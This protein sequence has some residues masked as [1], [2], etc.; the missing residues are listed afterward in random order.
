MS[1]VFPNGS[2]TVTTGGF[3]QGM[4][5]TG[6]PGFKNYSNPASAQ[7]AKGMDMSSYKPGQA[8]PVQQSQ[9]TPYQAWSSPTGNNERIQP[10]SR[11]A[12]D[13]FYAG[14]SP[15]FD[16]RTGQLR[17]PFQQVT[18]DW[19]GSYAAAP[20]DQRPPAFQMGPA[21]TPWGQSMDPFAE[22]NAFIEQLNQQRM[23]NQVAFNSGGTTNPAAG[24]TPG[25]NYQQAMQQAG[26][27]GGA[28]SMA[29]DY[30]DSMISRLNQAFSGQGDP[31]AFA[32]Q[33][34]YSPFVNQQGQQ[35]AGS[36]SFAPGTPQSYQ[37]QAY[38]NFANQ[39][40]YFQPPSQGTPYRQP[41]GQAQ[42]GV[43][44]TYNGM[45][46]VYINGVPGVITIGTAGAPGNNGFGTL[47]GEVFT[48]IP[49]P[50]QSAPPSQGTPYQ[51]PAQGTPQG[52]APPPR[53]NAIRMDPGSGKMVTYKNGQWTWEP[54]PISGTQP[55]DTSRFGEGQK[56][57]QAQPIQPPSQGTPHAGGQKFKYD[58]DPTLGNAEFTKW[59]DARSPARVTLYDRAANEKAYDQFLAEKGQPPYGPG[60]P[61]YGAEQNARDPRSKE[62]N[63]RKIP[64][65]S[66]DV[67]SN[68]ER[69]SEYYRR[70]KGSPPR[71]YPGAPSDGQ[72]RGRWA[73]YSEP[74]QAQPIQPPSQ[75]M[76]TYPERKYEEYQEWAR[77]NPEKARELLRQSQE[78]L[79]PRGPWAGPADGEPAQPSR[80]GQAQP[81]QPPSQGTPYRQPDDPYAVTDLKS[82]PFYKELMVGDTVR[83]NELGQ[84]NVFDSSGKNVRQYGNESQRYQLIGQGKGGRTGQTMW[85]A[86]PEGAAEQAATLQRLKEREAVEVAAFQKDVQPKIN[87]LNELSKQQGAFFASPQFKKRG[88]TPPGAAE[89]Q[90]LLMWARQFVSSG[91][92]DSRLSKQ[93]QASLSW[94]IGQ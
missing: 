81:V 68:F 71:G 70:M 13:T 23:Q 11:P 9:G 44:Q 37:D 26:L 69:E 78:T 20:P 53:E 48:P 52:S 90:N 47:G 15:N 39:Q 59:L 85:G 4:T 87:R 45:P 24:M 72:E 43:P 66:F 31:F 80:P 88:G 28:P 73:L 84:Y 29:P 5:K 67:K 56:T 49:Q 3:G 18:G 92:L 27:S 86:T 50:P 54:N 82:L 77:K 94:M 51:P 93:Q 19:Q 74:G 58:K 21:Q 34:A 17:Q 42:Q 57:G 41:A 63:G 30:G 33:S 65:P 55:Y 6:Q 22:R 83:K 64:S 89:Y 35:F 7:P 32:G 8:Q 62:N 38:G 36:M 40:G 14:G 61:A 79:W 1:L 60:M 75:G 25:L 46:V 16:E 2:R 76:M 10:A 12:G 91:S